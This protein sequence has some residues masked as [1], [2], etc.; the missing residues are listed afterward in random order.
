MAAIDGFGGVAACAGAVMTA[1]V[2][3]APAV[4]TAAADTRRMPVVRILKVNAPLSLMRELS[5]PRLNALGALEAR[6]A[7]TDKTPEGVG[8]MYGGREK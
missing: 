7:A 1:V 4:T 2:M 8:G 3:T 6:G 5:G